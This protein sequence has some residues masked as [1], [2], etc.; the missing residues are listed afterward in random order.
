MAL[1]RVLSEKDRVEGIVDVGVVVIAHFENP[2]NKQAL[3]FIRNVLLWK[4]RCLVPTSTLIGAYHI[5][6]SYLGVERDS[7]C[8]ALLKTLKTLSPAFYEDITIELASEAIVNATSYKIASWDGYIISLARIYNAPTIY[9]IDSKL[10][11]KVKDIQIINPIPE[12][13]FKKYN[14]WLESKLT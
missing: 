8:N 10:A 2:A 5:L 9:T 7:A 12:E 3:E 13:A 4:R 14:E 6:T 1:E 11:S